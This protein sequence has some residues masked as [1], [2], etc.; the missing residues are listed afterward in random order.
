MP[1]G[2][3]KPFWVPVPLEHVEHA[4]RPRA[5]EHSDKALIVMDESVWPIQYGAD[6]Q[7]LIVPIGVP[8]QNGEMQTAEGLT[9][10]VSG[11]FQGV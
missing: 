5:R 11:Q 10:A 2:P 4:G 8:K 9:V 3:H 1:F 6:F 7:G